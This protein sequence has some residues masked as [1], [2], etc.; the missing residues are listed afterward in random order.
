MA[1]RAAMA[2][3]PT[4]LVGKRSNSSVRRRGVT[5]IEM[6]VVVA[7]IA[8]VAGISYPTMAAG[9]ETLR[10][11]AA[12]RTVVSFVN[13]GLNRAERRQ[14]VVEIVISKP[15]R[16]LWLEAAGFE[17]KLELPDGVRIEAVFPE[18]PEEETDAPRSFMLY[19]GG[20]APAFAVALVN[21][22]RA[23]RIVRV[24]PVTGVP[25]IETPSSIK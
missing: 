6:M 20:T 18:L 15:Q 11:N 16:A 2:P 14:Q 17:R 23:E 3:M 5:L 19:P 13:S 8:I 22:K 1:R 9:V 4:L 25:I 12:A 7:L 24:D 21:A 10:L